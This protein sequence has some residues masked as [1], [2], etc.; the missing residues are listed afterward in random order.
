MSPTQE[1]EFLGKLVNTNTLLVS[2]SAD[3]VKKMWAEAIK[4]SNV[5]SLSDHLLSHFL[6]KL[7]TASQ[8]IPSA[9]LFYHC[10]QTDLQYK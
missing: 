3:K 5:V 4:I 7:S 2:L 9:P 10:L 8:A 1:L 6:G